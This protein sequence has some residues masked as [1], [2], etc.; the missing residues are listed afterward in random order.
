V[1]LIQFL[2]CFFKSK[3]PTPP[4]F[5]SNSGSHLKQQKDGGDVNLEKKKRNKE[6]KKERKKQRKK[7]KKVAE[8]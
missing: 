1:F 3:F 2:C 8:P 4:S 5:P 7:R 6:R